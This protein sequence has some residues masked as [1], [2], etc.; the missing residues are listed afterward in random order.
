MCHAKSC[1]CVRSQVH[2]KQEL[3]S[4]AS[5]HIPTTFK[6]NEHLKRGGSAMPCHANH[7]EP[8]RPDSLF[9]HKNFFENFWFD[10][11]VMTYPVCVR[12]FSSSLKTQSPFLQTPTHSKTYQK[13]TKHKNTR[14]RPLMPGMPGM[15]CM[16]HPTLHGVHGTTIFSETAPSHLS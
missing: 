9:C 12:A 11:C 6:N 13:C 14:Y 1:A 10:T 3:D 5:F 7:E 15:P 4:C 8:S 16:R 2:P